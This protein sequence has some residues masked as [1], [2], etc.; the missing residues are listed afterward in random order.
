MRAQIQIALRIGAALLLVSALSLV[1]DP[2]GAHKLISVH[3]YNSTTHFI[4]AANM[5]G[6]AVIM[7]VMG[8]NPESD[9]TGALAMALLTVGIVIGHQM[10][11]SHSMPHGIYTVVALIVVIGLAV[12]LL[13]ARTQ[14]MAASA[15]PAKRPERAPANKPAA[16]KTSKKKAVKKKVTKKKATKKRR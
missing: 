8:E 5:L 2:T 12:F 7:L 1:A 9:F 15:A 3:A 14:E 16:K 10:L 13:V 11:V 6:M 4:L